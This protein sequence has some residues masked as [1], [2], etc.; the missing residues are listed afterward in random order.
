MQPDLGI[1]RA[2]QVRILQT[3]KPR[4]LLQN[5]LSSLHEWNTMFIILTRCVSQKGSGSFP[6]VAGSCHC[7]LPCPW[8]GL[9]NRHTR[10]YLRLSSSRNQTK[11]QESPL[12]GPVP[13]YL[14][15]PTYMT[16]WKNEKD[17]YLGGPDLGKAKQ[18][19]ICFNARSSTMT[20]EFILQVFPLPWH[21]EN[22][23]SNVSLSRCREIT[24]NMMHSR[25][26]VI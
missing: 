14:L 4:V 16:L 20:S 21:E 5:S 26:I 18:L 12:E 1:S 19:S 6:T 13:E 17:S 15:V 3:L 9:Y 2:A 22:N 23:F 10:L 7:L 8:G 25:R 24:E 11:G